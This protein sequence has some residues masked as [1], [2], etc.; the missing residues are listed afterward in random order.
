M[1][2]YNKPPLVFLGNKRNQLGNI[3]RVLENMF[4]DRTINK[5][6][7]IYDVF[8]GSGLVSHNI[9]VWYPKNDVIYNDF[10][11]YCVRLKQAPITEEIRERI[12]TDILTKKGDKLSLEEKQGLKMSRLNQV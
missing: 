3:K 5:E 10:D 6:T 8:G 1:I 12:D 4:I 7:I 2:Q 9:K 11:N